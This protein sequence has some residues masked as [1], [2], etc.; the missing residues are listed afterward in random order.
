[1]TTVLVIL[2]SNHK[3]KKWNN[4]VMQKFNVNSKLLR[5]HEYVLEKNRIINLGYQKFGKVN[6]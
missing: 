5:I 6:H 1:M 4:Y 3:K 2:F